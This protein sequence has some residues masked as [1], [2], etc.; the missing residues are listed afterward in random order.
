MRFALVIIETEHSKRQIRDD[1][2]G[3]RARLET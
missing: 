1:L 2:A 3:H